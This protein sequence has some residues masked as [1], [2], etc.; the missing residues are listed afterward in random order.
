MTRSS[1]AILPSL[2]LSGLLTVGC[3][4][5]I[6]NPAGPGGAGDS[7]SLAGRGNSVGDPNGVGSNAL[8]ARCVNKAVGTNA[9]RRLTHREYANAVRDLLGPSATL[10]QAFA[11]DQQRE[12]FDTMANQAVSGLLADQYLDTATSLAEGVT[13]A[14]ALLGCDPGTATCVQGFIKKFGRRAYRRPVTDA[15]QKSLTALYDTTRAAADANTGVQAVVAAVLASPNFLFRPEFGAGSASLN[16]VKSTPFEV[17]ARLSF[18]LWASLPDDV[19]LDAAANNTLSSKEQIASQ[20]RRMLDDARA[21]TGVLAFYEQWFGLGRLATTT[22]D[23]ATYPTFNDSLRS[24]MGEE[25]RRFI[26]DVLFEGD[27]KLSTM[28][29]ASY[30]FVNSDLAK[31]YGVKGPSDA[32][33]FSKVNLDPEER[34]GVLTQ[35]SIMATYAAA[36]ESSPVKRGKWVRTRMLCQDLPDPPPGIP[37]LPAPKQGMSTRERFAQHTADA[38]CAG[39]HK[40]IDGLGFG[41]E[42]YDGIGA[43]RSLD[44]GV[45]IDSRGEI[46]STSD[47]D[48]EY[49]GA[50]QLASI[51]AES[52]HVRDCVP[53]QWFRYAAGRRETA[54]DACALAAMQETF[55]AQDGDLEQ[56]LMAFVQSDAFAHYRK[57]AD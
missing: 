55:K 28:L 57:S 3:T 23:N 16:G 34:S 8:S 48:G 56:L 19:L 36:D 4:G 47:A 38:K 12:M 2:L 54:D 37:S 21:K 26:Q 50:P 10:G 15:E 25:T 43:L 27:A 35:A 32:Q 39:C 42:R 6:A 17:A 9:M 14:R 7:S 45:T 31:L 29:T 49:D 40:L 41:L 5:N 52:E 18:L 53:V 44:H 22:K 33:T 51:L 13:D 1:R 11:P 24:A 20:A 46:T 30:S